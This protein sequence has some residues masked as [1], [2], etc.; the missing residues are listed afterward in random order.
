MLTGIDWKSVQ[1][2]KTR[3]VWDYFMA[4]QWHFLIYVVS[5]QCVLFCMM[6]L[7]SQMAD[8]FAVDFKWLQKFKIAGSLQFFI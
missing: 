1:P 8:V 3:D 2:D 7:L 5:K 6:P 4:T